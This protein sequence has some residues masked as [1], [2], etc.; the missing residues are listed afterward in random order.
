MKSSSRQTAFI[1]FL[2]VFSLLIGCAMPSPNRMV[3]LDRERYICK[4]DP[5]PY[6]KLQGK[7]ILLST[8]IDKSTNTSNLSY[9]NPSQTIGYELY[10]SST[11][12]RQPVVSFFWY[13]LKKAFECAG[14]RIEEH[15]PIYDAELYL[16][17]NSLTDE[18]IIFS[19]I[20]SKMGKVL[21]SRD[22]IIVMPKV[23]TEEDS[24]L[25]QRAY[26][27][28]DAITTTILNKSEFQKAVSD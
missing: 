21:Y 25:E 9:Y 13:S 18:E 6:S 26:R 2:L 19:A 27:M 24:V 20:L 4:I 14:I 12:M 10:Y 16:A 3:K 15:G 28:L 17:F 5:A 22:H 8:I 1:L 11:S 23:K 7:R